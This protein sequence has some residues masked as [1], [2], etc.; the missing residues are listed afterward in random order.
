MCVEGAGVE[1]RR[2]VV[3]SDLSIEKA[4]VLLECLASQQ[5]RLARILRIRHC[6][7]KRLC[8]APCP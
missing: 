2:G 6:A 3:E 8:R 1:E 7:R 5:L 4:E